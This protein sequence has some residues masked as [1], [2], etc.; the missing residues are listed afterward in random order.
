MKR[1]FWEE[2]IDRQLTNRIHRYMNAFDRY[3]EQLRYVTS[4]N[5][6]IDAVTSDLTSSGVTREYF[7]K[8]DERCNNLLDFFQEKVTKQ[9][10]RDA[11][12]GIVT[13][14]G[15]QDDEDL[16]LCLLMDFVHCFEGL[17]HRT[18]LNSRE[19]LALLNVIAK[20]YRPDYYMSF[21]EL[22]EI[23]QFIINLDSMVSYIGGCIE[24][25]DVMKNQSIVSVLLQ[26]V[27][28]EA[29]KEYRI[30]LYKLCEAISEAD[31]VISISEREFLM[32]VLR[33]DDDDV[34]NDIITDSIFNRNE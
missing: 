7:N 21:E 3:F 10:V 20:V 24:E 16:M 19:G 29:D 18:S 23:P 26:I 33:L 13:M 8:I 2:K 5:P 9:D 31:G 22:S 17:D 30:L 6:D 12:Q 25:T 28:P 11:L 4:I 27:N 32:N 34:T 1:T 14:E 15:Y